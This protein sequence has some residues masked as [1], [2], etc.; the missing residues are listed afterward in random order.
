MK[1]CEGVFVNMEIVQGKSGSNICGVDK[2][3]SGSVLGLT[4]ACI[5]VV[6]PLFVVVKKKNEL[7]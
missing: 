2:D 1:L 4:L 5:F 6:P 7:R 3:V